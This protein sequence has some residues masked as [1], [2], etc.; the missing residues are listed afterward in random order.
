MHNENQLVLCVDIGNTTTKLGYFEK[1]KLKRIEKFKN[2]EYINILN[3]P[4][5][6]AII[7]SVNR[8]VEKKLLS[9]LKV[10]DI[11]IVGKQIKIDKLPLK[12]RYTSPNKL[13]SDRVCFS[14]YSFMKYK[15]SILNISLGTALVIDHLN[16]KGEFAGGIIIPGITSQIQA[17]KQCEGL[18]NIKYRKVFRKVLGNNT[19]E[20]ISTGISF[21]IVNLIKF[22]KE[23]TKS[24]Y[25][26]ISGGDYRRIEYFLKRKINYIYQ[27]NAV[28]L[29]LYELYKYT[30]NTKVNAIAK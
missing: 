24:K 17:L 23:W 25:I 18:Q 11:Y 13:G 22:Y 9:Y 5:N 29:G 2:D 26:V 16:N 21:S 3:R 28:V 8:K 4:I 12:F 27:P 7:S 1:G 10:K 14:F 20:C 30:L 15:K 6:I 19:D